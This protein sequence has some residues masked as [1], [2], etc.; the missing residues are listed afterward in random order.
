[1][2]NPIRT[3]FENISFDV[4]QKQLIIEIELPSHV[5]ILVSQWFDQ[6]VKIQGFDG[7]M[8]FTI[9]EY[10]E[11]TSFISDGKRVDISLSFD[12]Y[13]NKPSL[14]QTR[15]IEGSV[16]SYGTLTGN[17]SLS[18]FDTII[19]NTQSDLILRLTRDLKS[20]I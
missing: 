9:S 11:E 2:V 15:M 19:K 10:L 1:F 13:I 14:S 17:F 4:V 16:Y 8:Q 6:K 20:K 18:E 12:V 5:Q 3:D 7:E